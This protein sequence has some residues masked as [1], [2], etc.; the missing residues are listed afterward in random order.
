MTFGF[1]L[2]KRSLAILVATVLVA[3]NPSCSD[4]QVSGVGMVQASDR[5]ALKV[6]SNILEQGQ[7]LEADGSWG[8]ALAHYEEALRDHPGQHAL[9]QRFDNARLHYSFDRRLGDRSFRR[10]I[11]SLN[12][13]QALEMYGELLSKIDTHYFET[14]PWQKLVYRGVRSLEIALA[15]QKFCSVHHLSINQDRLAQIRRE[16]RQTAV[17]SAIQTLD[18]AS[19]KAAEIARLVGYRTGLGESAVIME[20]LDQVWL[21]Y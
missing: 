5:Q 4:A 14:P 16:I 3:S 17:R 12:R 2:M 20:F 9:Q 21:K 19:T 8:D 18:D 7:S 1:E 6:V 13:N 11:E 15:N 10:T